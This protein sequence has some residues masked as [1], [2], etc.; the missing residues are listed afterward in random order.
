MIWRGTKRIKL[1][2]SSWSF[3]G[4]DVRFLVWPRFFGH[5]YGTMENRATLRIAIA[6]L[7]FMGEQTNFTAAFE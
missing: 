7:E 2:L 5:L 1:H 4:A 3:S 6:P